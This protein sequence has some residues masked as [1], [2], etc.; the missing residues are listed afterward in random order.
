M[1]VIKLTNELISTFEDA[2][3]YCPGRAVPE[4]YR[5]PSSR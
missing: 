5:M 4:P 1:S 2:A 3:G